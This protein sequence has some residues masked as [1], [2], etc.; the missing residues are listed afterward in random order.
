L[1]LLSL[2][3]LNSVSEVSMIENWAGKCASG[4]TALATGVAM[5]EYP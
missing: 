2:R 3:F 4:I 5:S 1:E